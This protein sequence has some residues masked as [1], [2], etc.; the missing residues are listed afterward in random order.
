MIVMEYRDWMA[1]KQQQYIQIGLALNA[2]SRSLEIQHICVSHGYPK[3]LWS[4][5]PQNT[6]SQHLRPSPIKDVN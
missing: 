2:L 5:S 4:T 6:H 1:G 3:E